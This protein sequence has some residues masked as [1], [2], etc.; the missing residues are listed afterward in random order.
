MNTLLRRSVT[1]LRRYKTYQLVAAFVVFW[2]PVI[3]FSKLAGEILEREPI[4]LD[5]AI[6]QWIHATASPLLDGIFLFFTTAGDV[7]FIL[8]IT[9]TIIAF[10]LYKKQRTNA[11]IVAFGVGGA[12]VANLVLKELFHRDRPA[13]WQS[14]ITETGYSFPSGHSMISAALIVCLVALLWTTRWR[15]VSIIIG[16]S[17]IVMVGLS[18]LYMGVHYPTDVVAGW[19]AGLVW[20]LLVVVIVRDVSP[21]LK[22]RFKK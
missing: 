6:L 12:A 10:L 20:A 2:T 15:F 8:P 19:S 13:F 17:V 11:L 1:H 5:T 4:A 9:A 21:K 22:N 7:E 3:V 14:L 18:R 16:G